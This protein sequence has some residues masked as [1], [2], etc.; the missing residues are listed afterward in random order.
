MAEVI[1]RIHSWT[2]IDDKNSMILSCF[3]QDHKTNNPVACLLN[4]NSYSVY[5]YMWSS[6]NTNSSRYCSKNH[7][8][9][10]SQPVKHGTF[11]N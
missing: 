1:A 3:K 8:Q 5:Y 11:V 6:E 7:V 2:F 9:S 10:N 4:L